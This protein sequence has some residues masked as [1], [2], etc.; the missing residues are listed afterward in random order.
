MD[1]Q[2]VTING[3]S[4]HFQTGQTILEVAA[5]NDIKIPTLCHLKGAT[6]TG[7]CRICVV[8][9]E[10]ARTLLPACSTPAASGMI[11]HTESPKVVSARK[12]ILELMLAS[13]NHSSCIGACK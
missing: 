8:E 6:P 4:F 5:E 13:G 10:G 12:T 1:A 11:I 7:A 3:R 9:V 2:Q